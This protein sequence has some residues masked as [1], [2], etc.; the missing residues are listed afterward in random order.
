L[1]ETEVTLQALLH[2]GIVSED[3]RLRVK[4]ALLIVWIC[5][6]A[7]GVFCC[8]VIPI[9][10]GFDEPFHFAH[11]QNVALGGVRAYVPREVAQSFAY[12]PLPSFLT[13]V[14]SRSL[15]HDQFNRIPEEQRETRIADLYQLTPQRR[16]EPPYGT[17]RSYEAQQPPLYYI[18]F[19]PVYW[20][21]Q[22]ISLPDRV[23]AIRLAG[24][25]LASL[26]I[27]FGFLAARSAVGNRWHAVAVVALATSMPQLIFTVFR[28]SNDAL[29]VV[30]G[31]VLLWLTLR[32][33][34]LN[35]LILGAVLGAALLTKAYF[36]SALPVVLGVLLWRR[37]WQRAGAVIVTALVIAGW[38]YVETYTR[39]G[40]V[41]GE[42]TTIDAQH[43][44]PA[45]LHVDWRRALDTTF[46]SH[47]WFGN[48]S[49]VTLRSWMYRVFMML[50]AAAGI[51][52][53]SRRTSE[54]AVV[55][56]FWIALAL[57]LAYHVLVNTA[58]HGVS[59]TNGWYLYAVVIAECVLLTAG[60]RW[61]GPALALCFA[62]ADLFG[63]TFYLLPYYSGLT[64]HTAEGSLHA[65]TIA[66]LK[67]LPKLALVVMYWTVSIISVIVCF[68][69]TSHAIQ[70]SH[71]EVPRRVDAQ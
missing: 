28:V 61:M 26:V 8:G 37:E 10:E 53:V 7:R 55:V 69:A 42:Q 21:V 33:P 35:P 32:R 41:T 3:I 19:C 30:L 68:I 48:W 56:A 50:Y 59:A 22:S 18:L 54:M 64:V 25:L 14:G 49:F 1:L 62:A 6:I 71:T 58:V 65:A 5:F 23:L 66:Q 46:V 15:T 29:A 27:P 12:A 9:W 63:M 20:L 16:N 39:T 4:E 60:I 70:R 24:V 40:S 52:L 44:T 51:A 38:Y 67:A 36:L 57:G 2:G 43:R 17:I 11:L 47:I 31:A 13:Y 34:A 45:I